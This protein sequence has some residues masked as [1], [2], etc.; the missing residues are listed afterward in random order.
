MSSLD[1]YGAGFHPAGAVIAHP[2]L[3]RA[4]YIHRRMTSPAFE[5]GML[6]TNDVDDALN[7][8]VAVAWWAMSPIVTPPRS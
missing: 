4:G 8:D 6:T 7:E 1:R 5:A 3:V 2:L